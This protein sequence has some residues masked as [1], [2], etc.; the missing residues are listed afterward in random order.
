[1]A[2]K[3]FI[4]GWLELGWLCCEGAREGVRWIL[5]ERITAIYTDEGRRGRTDGEE[6]AAEK[7]I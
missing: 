7:F 2:M 5:E 3:D 4:F 6:V 1:M